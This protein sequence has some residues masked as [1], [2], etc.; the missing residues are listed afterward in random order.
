MGASMALDPAA[1]RDGIVERVRELCKGPNDRPF[2]GGT[3]WGRVGNS[4]MARGADFVIE[5]AGVQAFPPKVEPQP[6]PTNVKTVQQAWDCTRMGGYVML[7]GFDPARALPRH[8]A[9]PRTHHPSR[10]AGHPQRDGRSPALRET[11]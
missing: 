1:E 6:D 9:G 10:P 8:A 3:S 5:A 2:A 4:I 11:D 7:M